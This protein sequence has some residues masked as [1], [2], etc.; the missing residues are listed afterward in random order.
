MAPDGVLVGG[1]TDGYLMLFDTAMP[2]PAPF[3]PQL[4]M[5]TVSVIRAGRRIDFPVDRPFELLPNDRQLIVGARLLSFG[6][7]LSNRYSYWLKGFDTGWIDQGVAVHGNSPRCP[8]L[9]TH[10]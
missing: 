5:E 6:D 10:Y 3:V 4:R 2:D 1:T 7:P 8:R 9:T